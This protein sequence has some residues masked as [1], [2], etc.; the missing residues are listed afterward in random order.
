MKEMTMIQP[1]EWQSGKDRKATLVDTLRQLYE[2]REQYASSRIAA[3]AALDRLE[4][5]RLYRESER[6]R[7][8]EHEANTKWLSLER[9]AYELAQELMLEQ[10][11]ASLPAGVEVVTQRRLV[12]T[13]DAGRNA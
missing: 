4:R 1:D 7:E 5:T 2:A 3:S 13:A 11:E 6:A 12:I 8:R 9:R 10:G